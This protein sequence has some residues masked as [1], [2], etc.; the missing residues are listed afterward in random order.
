M[1]FRRY[2]VPLALIALLGGMAAYSFVTF[3][4]STLQVANSSPPSYDSNGV[5]F[6][7]PGIANMLVS[8]Y[9]ERDNISSSTCYFGVSISLS[10]KTSLTNALATKMVTLQLLDSPFSSI[11]VASYENADSMS[12]SYSKDNSGD[13]SATLTTPAVM[14]G[15]TWGFDF[16]VLNAPINSTGGAAMNLIFS[17]YL[18]HAGYLGHNYNIQASTQYPFS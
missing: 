2:A 13:V 4:N 18:V 6:A 12:V 7:F 10:T 1:R 15:S 5:D 9:C 16:L 11:A 14:A 3:S 17:A 8:G